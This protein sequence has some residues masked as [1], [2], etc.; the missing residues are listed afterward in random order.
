MYTEVTREGVHK[1]RVI[2][3][4]ESIPPGLYVKITRQNAETWICN[5]YKSPK[6]FLHSKLSTAMGDVGN[7]LT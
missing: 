5:R 2:N 3:R 1:K 6:R 4:P 7:N